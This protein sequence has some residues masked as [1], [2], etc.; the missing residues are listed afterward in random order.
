MHPG[1]EICNGGDDKTD[2]VVKSVTYSRNLS[3]LKILGAG[4]GHKPGIIGELGKQLSDSRINIY[5]VITSQTC[6]NFLIDSRDAQ[7]S[8]LALKKVT[9][10]VIEKIENRGNIAL[11][12]VVGDGILRTHGLAAKVFGAVAR[13]KVNVEMISAGASETAYYFI[14]DSGDLDKAVNAVHG[15]FFGSGR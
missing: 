12:A 1:T 13:Q 9:G 15:E 7:R 2:R 10:G 8:L 4:V 5:S 3:V 11:I 6:I 14:V